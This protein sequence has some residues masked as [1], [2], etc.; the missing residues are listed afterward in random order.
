MD[1]KKYVNL[2]VD[3]RLNAIDNLVVFVYIT[4]LSTH[5]DT[6]R[7][8]PSYI[9]RT[10]CRKAINSAHFFL[11]NRTFLSLLSGSIFPGQIYSP[12]LSILL[13]P[14]YLYFKQ[15]LSLCCKQ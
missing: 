3:N 8:S 9:T 11:L 1:K 6:P 4:T 7:Y 14:F 5:I 15:E 12:Y 13:A 10:V 2:N